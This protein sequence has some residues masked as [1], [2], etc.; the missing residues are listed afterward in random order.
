MS[1]WTLT[2]PSGGKDKLSTKTRPQDID[3][4]YH[5]LEIGLVDCFLYKKNKIPGSFH[6]EQLHIALDSMKYREIL[7]F[8]LN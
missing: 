8:H 4:I 2:R 6:S 3:K 7:K 1:F 5:A